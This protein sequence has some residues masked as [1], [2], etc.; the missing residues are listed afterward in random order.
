[1]SIW[2]VSTG[3][4]GTVTVQADTVVVDLGILEFFTGTDPNVPAVLVAAFR[5]WL[6]FNPQGM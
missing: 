4:S 2:T 5:D 1:M 3:D 6:W